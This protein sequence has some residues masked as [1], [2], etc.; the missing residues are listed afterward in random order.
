MG[1][2]RKPAAA[3]AREGGTAR[4]GTVSHRPQESTELVVVAG[5]DVP[6]AAPD[7]LP[8]HARDLWVEIV[9]ALA[10]AGIIDKIDLPALRWF[11]LEH[12]R[13]WQAKTVLDAPV[14]EDEM[15]GLDDQIRGMD[16]IASNLQSQ[17]ANMIRAG[18]NVPPA[19]V[20]ALANYATTLAN[21]RH[22]RAMKRKVGNLVSLG[23][24]GQ[25]IENPLL[26]TERAAATLV[27]SFAG[28]FGL[29]PADRA[30]LGI[31]ILEG[32]T[33]KKE[34]DDE[35]GRPAKRPKS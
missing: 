1:R 13:G 7:E 28:R 8:E 30:A 3:R 5:R 23:S 10:R 6:I 14:D 17:V 25:V 12:A 26:G 32:R 29:T 20:N 18:V 11:C 9:E 31:A 15:Q 19:Q 34:L 24:T 21:L 27:K 2:P 33:M 16:A 22:Y 35:I 4:A